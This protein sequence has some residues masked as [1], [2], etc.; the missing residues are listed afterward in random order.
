MQVNRSPGEGRSAIVYGPAH[1]IPSLTGDEDN[2]ATARN[3]DAGGQS[4]CVQSW[5]S[6][7]QVASYAKASQSPLVSH[8]LIPR[9]RVAVYCGGF[10]S[11]GRRG[12]SIAGGRC[13]A[14]GA[15]K[16]VLSAIAS[17][18]LLTL[19]RACGGS[20]VAWYN[21]RLFR[22][23]NPIAPNTDAGAFATFRCERWCLMSSRCWRSAPA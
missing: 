15:A 8:R 3:R 7:A 19:G 17:S 16:R 1:L 5:L 9:P 14:I 2:E 4:A 22:R 6:R 13:I 10:D 11:A 21:R 23:S 12:H 20:R 18:D